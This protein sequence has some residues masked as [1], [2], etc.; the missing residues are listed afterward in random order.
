MK[1]VIL[2]VFALVLVVVGLVSATA[3]EG[4]IVDVRAHV[5]NA[6][7]VDPYE[8]NYGNFTFPQESIDEYLCIGL[9]TSF[10][11]ANQLRLCDVKYALIWEPKPIAG[12]QPVPG[13]QEICDP[14][15]DGNF[16]PIAPFILL[17]TADGSDNQQPYPAW[18]P[19]NAAGWGTLDKCLPDNCDTWGLKFDVPVFEGYYNPDTDPMTP[20]GV[21]TPDEYCLVEEL[22]GCDQCPERAVL[23]P[24]AD[25]GNILKIQVMGYSIMED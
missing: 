4:H 19:A 6:L 1:R 15:G 5:E 9:T 10:L 2:I 3:F 14:D 12:H 22:V 8:I 13:Q 23:V 17:T 21:L 20:S 7:W 24:H 16:T 18:V 25:L 11:N